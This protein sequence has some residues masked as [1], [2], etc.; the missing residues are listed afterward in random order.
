VKKKREKEEK[1]V[2]IKS[3]KDISVLKETERK[4]KRV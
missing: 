3:E 2:E 4:E 1:S